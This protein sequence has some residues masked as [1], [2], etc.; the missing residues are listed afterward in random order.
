MKTLTILE[1]RV[2]KSA[3]NEG[4]IYDGTYDEEATSHF[5]CWGFSG[6]QD[7]GAVS[8]LIKKGIISVYK[9]D[10]NTYVYLNMSRDEAENI[11]K[12]V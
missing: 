4:Y 9:E 6:K 3:L 2:L 5:L 8:S 12:G 11:C 7:R 10:D 1:K